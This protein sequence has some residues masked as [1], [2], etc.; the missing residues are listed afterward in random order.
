M[1]D[2]RGDSASTRPAALFPG[3]PQTPTSVHAFGTGTVR[4]AHSFV[5]PLQNKH[6]QNDNMDKILTTSER[7]RH[8]LVNLTH[9]I[10]FVEE[11]Y[12]FAQQAG[13]NTQCITAFCRMSMV[14][15]YPFLD[16]VGLTNGSLR[17]RNAAGDAAVALAHAPELAADLL[18]LE[19]TAERQWDSDRLWQHKDGCEILRWKA[20]FPFTSLSAPVQQCLFHMG[21]RGSRF[22]VNICHD[23][24]VS[25]IIGL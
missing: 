21:G 12:N 23:H 6:T 4:H 3:R 9:F 17:S 18:S 11:N 10:K 25:I 2:W 8:V 13:W 5:A 14:C 7:R 20:A 1:P 16:G 24:T 19:K 15:M 22:I